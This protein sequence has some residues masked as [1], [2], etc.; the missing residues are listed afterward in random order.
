MERNALRHG[1]LVSGLVVASGF[2]IPLRGQ[3]VDQG[4][5]AGAHVGGLF[6]TAPSFSES[7]CSAETTF[8]WG[9]HLGYEF[10]TFLGVEGGIS[11]HHDNPDLCVNGL[12][13][14]PPENGTRTIR[15]LGENVRGYPFLTPEGRLLIRSP[16]LGGIASARVSLGGAWIPSKEIG[17]L[18]AGLGVRA[19]FDRVRVMLNLE[20]WWFDVPF[21]DLEETFQDGE[22]VSAREI[23]GEFLENPIQ[24]RASVQW[25]IF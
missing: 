18:L 1:V 5:Y 2:G 24:L 14:P 25:F 7:I 9:A 15:S 11:S 22:L 17:V 3:G 23:P 20:R 13:R 4:V 12:V 16:R 21:T 10:M 19:S 6:G 8:L